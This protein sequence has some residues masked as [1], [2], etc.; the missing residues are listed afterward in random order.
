MDFI[1]GESLSNV[2]SQHGACPQLKAIEILRPVCEALA[3][4][5]S[6]GVVHRNL[7][8]DNIMLPK[9]GDRNTCVQVIDF[10]IAKLMYQD[11]NLPNLTI[12][13]EVLGSPSYMSPEQCQGHKI[14][15][16]SDIYSL[17]CVLY[18][19]LTGAPPFRG[20]Y[21]SVLR[22]QANETPAPLPP[23]L[24]PELQN[25]VSRCLNKDP[26][27]RYQDL[28]QLIADFDLTVKGSAP[29]VQS[30]TPAPNGQETG[31]IGGRYQIVQHIGQGGM[32]TVLKA[33]HLTLNKIVAIKVLN[34]GRNLDELSI[35]RFEVEAQA[36]SKLSHPNLVPVFDYGFTAN[37]EPYLVMEFIEGEVL[38]VILRRERK[39]PLPDFIEFFTQMCKALNYLH[40]NGIIHRD[41]KT[42]NIIVQTIE[43]ERYVKLLDLG[44][45]KVLTDDGSG[46]QHLTATGTVFGSPLYM[47]PEQC[48]GQDVDVRSDIY[49]LGC[50]MYE[51]LAGKPPFSEENLLATM[52]KHMH[53]VPGKLT[54]IA[55]DRGQ[56]IAE[57]VARCLEKDRDLR[58]QTA[59]DLQAALTALSGGSNASTAARTAPNAMGVQTE[60][61]R[62]PARAT[63]SPPLPGPGGPP[64]PVP[65]YLLNVTSGT[66]QNADFSS[67]NPQAQQSEVVNKSWRGVQ[68]AF[69]DLTRDSLRLLARLTGASPPKTGDVPKPPPPAVP[70]F[71]NPVRV[72]A[73]LFW[74]FVFA[75][76]YSMYNSVTSARYQNTMNMGRSSAEESDVRSKEIREELDKLNSPSSSLK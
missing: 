1:E 30:V 28:N 27:Q 18:E 10:G 16:R 50:V 4:A 44:I 63:D 73:V 52:Y 15:H 19:L 21:S 3:Y 51:C 6:K 29:A 7:Q 32:G 41:I 55:D 71:L 43:H 66:E 5:H 31:V 62:A 67:A 13:G 8:P 58:F 22:A 76:V 39:L 38:D 75:Y 53:Q 47:S 42:S 45:A 49:S 40:K 34:P 48:M 2:L 61:A 70:W 24:L 65:W 33:R 56:A 69:L 11:D 35:K 25:I 36:S 9:P 72:L 23:N 59:N 37:N 64:P 54:D 20:D 17:G 74:C 68:I 26:Q 12:T 60:A 57:I 14:D 46:Q